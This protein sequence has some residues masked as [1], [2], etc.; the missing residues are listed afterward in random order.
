MQTESLVGGGGSGGPRSFGEMLA[1]IRREKGVLGLWAGYSASLVLTLNPSITFFL[2]Q[3]L[4]KSLVARQGWDDDDDAAPGVTFVLAA[5]SKV[6][7]TVVTYPFQIAK[8][9]AQVSPA[10]VERDEGEDLTEGNAG[11][12]NKKA[13]AEA[14]PEKGLAK[15]VR[16]LADETIFATVARIGRDEGFRALYDGMSSEL[17]KAFFSHGITMVAKD[18]VHKLLFRLYFAILAYLRRH[19]RT[20]ARLTQAASNLSD[21]LRDGYLKVTAAKADRWR[22]SKE[23]ITTN[24]LDGGQPRIIVR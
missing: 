1:D 7:A 14:E 21:G 5:V 11:K 22:R 17:L 3:M 12:E 13:E 16:S 8:T 2:Q 20:R 4:T 23:A 9:R 10:P 24:L 6:I 15:S 19:P 18:A